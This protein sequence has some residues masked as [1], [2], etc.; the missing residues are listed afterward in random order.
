MDGVNWQDYERGAAVIRERAG[1]RRPEIAVVLGSGLGRLADRVENAVRIPYAEIPGLPPS[2]VAS[3]AGV[4]VLGRLMGRE[5]AVLS[6][7]F[8]YYEGYDFA[9]VCAYVRIL[10]LLGVR[11]LLLTNAAGGVNAT[12][13]VGDFMLI[14]DHIKLCAESPSRG[15]VPPV[16]GQRFF[17]L[18]RAYTPRL[19]DVARECARRLEVPLKEGV[20]FFMAGPQFE[21]PA[22]IRAIRALGG[23]AVG[24]ST[25]PEAIAAA[26]C[27]MEVLGVSCITNLAAG[28]SGDGTVS[29][30]EVTANAAQV[31]GRFVALM[32]AI[33]AGV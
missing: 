21:T 23:D 16:F 13:R 19:Q 22:E 24:M 33:V 14:T 6:G 3:H 8:H 1:T 27:G 25:V 7:R 12:Y 9:T 15:A 29:D 17:D 30:D 28:M 20:Y 11:K 26:Q 2:T 31:S 4:L 32:E 5:T 18:S 10:H